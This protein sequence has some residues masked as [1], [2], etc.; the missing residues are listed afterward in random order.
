MYDPIDFLLYQTGSGIVYSVFQ[1]GSNVVRPSGTSAKFAIRL[2][3]FRLC[4]GLNYATC[5]VPYDSRLCC[6]VQA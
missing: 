4:A 6:L 3:E 2:N 5:F 1:K